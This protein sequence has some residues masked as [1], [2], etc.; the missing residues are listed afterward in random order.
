MRSRNRRTMNWVGFL[1]AA[2]LP[3]LWPGSSWATDGHFLHGAGPVNEAMG[4]ADTGLCLDAAG[5]IAWNPACTLRFENKR[6]EF[7]GIYFVPWRDLSS[8]VDAGAFG[9]GMPGA[10]LSGTTTSHRNASMMPGFAFVYHPQGS[11]TAYHI[12]MLAVSGFGVDYDQNT[13]FSNPIL[14]P[15]A[16]NGF[17]FGKIQSNYALLTIP[18]GLSHEVTDKLSVGV[19]VVP[20]FSMLKVIPA[21]F[22]APV[23]AGST[24][25]YYLSASKSASALGIGVQAGLQYKFSDIFSAGFAWHSPVWFRDFHWTATDLTGAKQKLTFNLDLPQLLTMGVGIT[26][27]K[28]THIG[29]DARWFNYADASGFDE[30]GYDPD[31]SVAGFGW[32]NIW[33]AGGGVEQQVTSGTK[34]LVGYNYSENP[35]PSQYAFFNT[36]APAIVQHHL[37]GGIEQALHGGWQLN[38]TY[39]HAF[40]NSLSGPWVSQQG[41]MPG[42][43]VTSRMSENSISVG[44]SKSF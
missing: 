41:P 4:G 17:G 18:I 12:G 31:D 9:P 22:E 32:K 24:M 37:G 10:T 5:S 21:P 33:A 1:L 28:R 27:S 3:L 38:A 19:S 29:F 20:A 44:L 26:P 35:I 13:N 43:S 39:Y 7:Y 34:I 42:T 23:T 16:P 14:T 8:T 6:L 40:R 11:R 15:Q 25:P 30:A 36:P 2:L